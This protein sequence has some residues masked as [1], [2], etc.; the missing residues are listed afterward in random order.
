VEKKQDCE[1]CGQPST[2]QNPTFK[3]F[4]VPKWLHTKCFDDYADEVLKVQSTEGLTRNIPLPNW[5]TGKATGPR[6]EP[7]EKKR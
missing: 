7:K 5:S 2:K 4:A 6:Q 1:R 3:Y